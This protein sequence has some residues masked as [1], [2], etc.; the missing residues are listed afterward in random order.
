MVTCTAG[1]PA[2]CHRHF[3][4]A[5][6]LTR[7]WAAPSGT[8]RRAGINTHCPE[9][10][11]SMCVQAFAEALRPVPRM[12]PWPLGS[13]LTDRDPPRQGSVTSK[14]HLLPVPVASGPL[15]RASLGQQGS[16]AWGPQPELQAHPPRGP[17]RQERRH[18]DCPRAVA[19]SL[20]ELGLGALGTHTPMSTTS[21]LRGSSC[22]R[23]HS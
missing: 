14:Q 23:E 11:A 15:R 22:Q 5:A 18:S 1:I 4:S 2:V 6:G 13:R 20:P 7:R 21:L 9:T 3:R 10:A 12:G 17:H 19:S 8:T 16:R